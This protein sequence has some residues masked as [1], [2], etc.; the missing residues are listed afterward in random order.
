MGGTQPCETVTILGRGGAAGAEGQVMKPFH[1]TDGGNG[2]LPSLIQV[3]EFPQDRRLAG[4]IAQLDEM[5]GGIVETAFRLHS[6][7]TVQKHFSHLAVGPGQAFFI[8]HHAM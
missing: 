7:S 3:G 4:R 6:A 8:A 1:A 5:F 2:V